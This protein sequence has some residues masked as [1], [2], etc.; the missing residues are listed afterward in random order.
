MPLNDLADYNG[1]YFLASADIALKARKEA[2]WGKR[3]PD[4]IF[5]HYV[6]PY[7]VNNENLDSFRIVYYKEISARIKGMDLK[8]AALEINHWCHE[9]VTYQPSDIR[10]S[11]PM[12]TVLSARGRCGEESTFSVN[13]LRTA[14]IPARQVYCPRWAHTDDNHAWVEVWID[15]RWFYM[16][17]C[18]P[19]PVLDR[20]WFTEPARRAM[21]VQTRSFGAPY[22]KENYIITQRN[23]GLVNCLSKYAITKRLYVKVV[24][25]D[26]NPAPNA[27]VEFKLYNYSEFYT[28]ASVPADERGISSFET[29]LGD[30]LVWASKGDDFNFAKVSVEQSDTVILK[31]DRTANGSSETDLDL[32]PPVVPVPMAGPSEDL[33]ARN[34]ERLNQEDSIRSKYT[35]SWITPEQA[36]TLAKELNIDTASVKHLLSKSMGNYK[37]ISSFL[38]NTEI[39]KR[40]RALDILGVVAEKDLRDVNEMVLEDHLQNLRSPLNQGT[41]QEMFIDYV[42]NPRIANELLVAWR[43]RLLKSLPGDLVANAPRNPALI[44]DYIDR[45][46]RISDDGNYYG[47]PL[48]PTGVDELKVSDRQSRSIYFVAISR[49][50]GI[51][52]RLEPGSN[53]PQYFSGSEWHDVWFAD[54]KMP[55]ERK[56]YITFISKETSPVPE[57]YINFTLA[58]YE[59]GHYTTLE[60]DFN[61][62]VGDFRDELPLEPGNYMLVT[63]N[64]LSDSKILSSLSFFDLNPGQHLVVNINL[65]K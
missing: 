7:R 56:G 57:Y 45:T 65:R 28:L 26:G 4:D 61:K 19:E 23:F 17:A 37:A 25:R 29:G 34:K 50:L 18:E 55:Q 63:G 10:T 20:G 38:R 30:L 24:D 39:A 44:K 46:I 52:A 27:S 54:Q 58:R 11:S 42:L 16:G 36:E 31:L 21:L 33:V 59:N 32:T 60:Y 48:T 22:G 6:L 43:G 12:C 62:K 5:L 9:K 51:P 35:S 14:G 47:T 8:D 15:G 13:A 3:I 64:R 1:D 2:K 49:T 40:T 41:D 53:V